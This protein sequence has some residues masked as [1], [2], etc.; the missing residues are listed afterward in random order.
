MAYQLVQVLNALSF[1]V[2]LLLAGLGLM[3]V[4]SLMNFINLTHGS[5]FLLGGYVA[6]R[7][8]GEGN[9]WWLALPASLLVAAVAA[10]LLDRVL[11][12]HFYDR[13][14]LMQVLLT[15]GLSIVFTD[16]M[17][18]GF[19]SDTLTPTLP[20]V[21]DGAVWIAG[22]PF[23]TYRLFLIVAGT[24]LALL[25]WVLFERTR[26]GSALRACVSDRAIA[27]TL[28]I[29]TRRVFTV[30]MMLAAALAGLAGALGA[31][32]L[33]VHPGLDEEI[34]L[35]ALLVVVIGGL[36]SIRGTVLSALLIGFST[37]YASV[38]FPE[39]SRA[40][41]LAVMI[42]ILVLRPAGLW[43]AHTRLV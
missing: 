24:V 25:L 33:S 30:G 32:V 9:A 29:D 10:L 41:T 26:W 38:W 34:L 23:P 17:R 43:Q 5:F 18:W 13:P 3:L 40:L 28:G 15:Y 7:W 14:H 16:L 21:L 20:G 1:S 36:G 8:L 12:R 2:L 11:F 27:E 37:T 19:G 31:G 42:L 35:L 22:L 6:T 4:L 39:F